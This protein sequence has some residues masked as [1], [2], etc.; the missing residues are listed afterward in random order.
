MGRPKTAPDEVSVHGEAFL[1][2]LVAERNASAHTLRAYKGDIA[3]YEAFLAKKD[4][5]AIR[6]EPSHAKLYM[7]ALDRQ[8]LA[9][10]SAA[11]RLSAL[12]QFHRF[13]L[14]ER[15]AAADPFAGVD[16]PKLGRPL[17][18]ILSEAETQALI[19]AARAAA[20][21]RL[22]CALE[23]LYGSG[24]RISELAGLKLSA[25][26]RDGRFLIVRGK[27]EKER[28]TPLSG[29]AREA[30]AA[31]RAV[32]DAALART[33]KTSP[34]L[35]P[36]AATAGHVTEAR[37]AQELKALAPTAG[38]EPKRLSPHVL[39]H[40]FASHLVDRGADL[41]AVQSMLGHSDI[42]T[43]QI[44]THVGGE[45]LKRVVAE[46]HPLAKRPAR[47]NAP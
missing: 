24:L 41:R 16:A 10:R 30:I 17:P 14:S 4:T 9:P 7:A 38:I 20:N 15:R 13:L 3:H 33:K 32:R 37:F 29:P 43:T 26:S 11:R 47:R 45:R 22:L 39:R 27:G 46:H 36:S 1:E 18:K 23:I 34:Y 35:F 44:Y 40:A 8:G 5:D 12:R 2:M 6:A 31:W 25:L 21:L 28:L 42:S 19:E